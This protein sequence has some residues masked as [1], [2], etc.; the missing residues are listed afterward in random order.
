MPQVGIFG[1]DPST[2]LF[3]V[4]P[5][6]PISGTLLQLQ[7]ALTAMPHKRICHTTFSSAQQREMPGRGFSMNTQA[8]STGLIKT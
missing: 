5:S 6:G 4:L 2:M 8:S 7:S 1:G 3:P